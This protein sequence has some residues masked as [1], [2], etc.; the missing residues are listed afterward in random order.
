MRQTAHPAQSEN[1]AYVIRLA[2]EVG[3]SCGFDLMPP[4][5]VR[6]GRG[7]DWNPKTRCIRIGRG[8][9]S[10][11]REYLWYIMAHELAHAQAEGREGHS[12]G[13]WL[14]L[15]SG[16][17]N[18]GKLN[19]L[20]YS[21]GYRETAIRVAEE[22]GLPDVPMPKSFKLAVG[23]TFD[24]SAGRKWKIQSR[25]RRAGEPYYRLKTRG[26]HCAIS[27]IALISKGISN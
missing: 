10:G 14:R 11:D 9:L 8:D 6:R 7:G 27:E 16:L 24:D 15:G 21:Y 4:I 26:W 12:R 20:R 23:S 3:S 18:A 19:L 5:Y 13:F 25:F 1:S 17:K 2:Q 22:Y